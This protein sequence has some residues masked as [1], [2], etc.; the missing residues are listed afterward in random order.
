MAIPFEARMPLTKSREE[1]YELKNHFMEEQPYHPPEA[2]S[3]PP[4]EEPDEPVHPY[5]SDGDLL[6]RIWTRPRQVISYLVE[7]EPSKYIIALLILRGISETFIRAMD[8][9][10]MGSFGLTAIIFLA[11]FVGPLGGLLSSFI[12]AALL[13]V[14]GR[15]LDGRADSEQIRLVI[16]WASVPIIL[17]LAVLP[18]EMILFGANLS[19]KN[20]PPWKRTLSWRNCLTRLLWDCP[21]GASTSFWLAFPKYN[22]FRSGKPCSTAYWPVCYWW[23]PSW[24]W[25]PCLWA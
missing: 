9:Q 24:F 13:S 6:L 2:H 18:I 17:L 15:W 16:A 11:V 12:G 4:S 5:Y 25:L 10:S 14:S 19:L 3:Y 7:Y 23:Y 8:K 20:N 1:M 22:S 21:D